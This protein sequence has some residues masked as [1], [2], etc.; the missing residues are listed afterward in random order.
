MK[1]L[2]IKKVSEVGIYSNYETA[3]QIM[4]SN[5]SFFK[6][7]EQKNLFAVIEKNSCKVVVYKKF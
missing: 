7:T 3:L 2:Q 6:K 5:N 1:K 4:N